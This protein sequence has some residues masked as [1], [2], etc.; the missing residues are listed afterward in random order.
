M[1]KLEGSYQYI[2]LLALAWK[3]FCNKEYQNQYCIYFVGNVYWTDAG[4][5]TIEMAKLDGSYRY[6]VASGNMEKPRSIVVHPD[7]G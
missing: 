6:I 4:H 3:I 1:A 2:F 5:S 7:L